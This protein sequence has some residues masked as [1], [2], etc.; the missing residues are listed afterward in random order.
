MAFLGQLRPIQDQEEEVLWNES[1]VPCL[2]HPSSAGPTWTKL[3]SH[4]S[5]RTPTFTQSEEG[6]G[7][8]D[9]HLPRALSRFAVIEHNPWPAAEMTELSEIPWRSRD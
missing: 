1:F 9:C 4:S 2:T 5:F 8:L 3:A 7:A 6:G